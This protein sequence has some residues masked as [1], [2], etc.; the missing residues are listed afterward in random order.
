MLRL[1]WTIVFL[2][3]LW[4]GWWAV[5]TLA[6]ERALER[7]LQSQQPDGPRVKIGRILTAGFPA[8]MDL[9]MVDLDLTDE[10]SGV[11]VAMDSLTLSAPTYWPGYLTARL[12]R[13]PIE[14]SAPM[15]QG[16]AQFADGSAGI[17][18]QP[19]IDLELQGLTAAAAAWQ[20]SLPDGPLLTAQDLRLVVDREDAT[21]AGYTFEASVRDLVPG[22]LVR[23]SLALPD[24][25]PRAFSALTAR[26][27]VAFDR[28]LDR[29]ALYGPPPQPRRLTITDLAL[30]WG[31]IDLRGSG[32]LQINAVGIPEGSITLIARNWPVLLRLAMDAG[33]VPP[34]M[35]VQ[36]RSILQALAS[37]RG[38]PETLDIELSFDEGQ[39]SLGPI[40]L[41]PAPRLAFR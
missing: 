17:R 40:R 28:P 30:V 39:M 4:C 12:P 19:G 21:P 35:D 24:S 38:D 41:G 15:G 32:D 8:T 9:K 33:M 16:T 26:G 3:I 2:G 34:G 31:D 36:A 7:A 29:G 5:A 23:D 10:D 27:G 13:T 22:V 18:L 20:V 25:W 6:A 11:A 14:V 37:M 1:L